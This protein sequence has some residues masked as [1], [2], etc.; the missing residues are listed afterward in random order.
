MLGAVLLLAASCGLTRGSDDAVAATVTLPSGG[1]VDIG[2][3]QLDELYQPLADD[4]GF[5]AGAYGGELP[6]GLRGQMLTDLVVDSVLADI[7]SN[8]SIEID[9]A[10]TDEGRGLLVN[11]V[12]SI[13]PDEEDPVATAEARFDSLPYLSFLAGLQAKQIA[14]GKGLAAVAPAGET[15]EVPCSSHILVATE[16]EALA[17]VAELEAGADFA[18]LATERSSDTSGAG[19]GALGCTDPEGFVPEFRDAI[20]GAPIGTIIGPVQT[21]FGFHVIT[22]TGVEEQTVGAPA[23]QELA[24]SEIVSSLSQ[25]SVDVD[26]TIGE[27]DA[28]SNSVIDAV[29]G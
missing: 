20:V 16:E 9:E 23:A 1:T 6:A 10:S 28:A 26:P 7:L 19:G 17:V 21:Q 15:A 8:K 3:D 24:I 13:F 27:W 2:R 11:A 4:V 22:V 14:L 18:Q 25:I 29:D 5:V 12:A